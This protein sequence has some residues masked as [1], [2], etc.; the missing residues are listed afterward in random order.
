[1]LQGCDGEL[2]ATVHENQSK[3]LVV[4]YKENEVD[5]FIITAYFA[6]KVDKLLKRKILWQK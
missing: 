6:T 4:V 2:L 5:G 1:V 3:L